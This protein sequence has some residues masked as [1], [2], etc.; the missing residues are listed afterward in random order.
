VFSKL[1]RVHDDT[2]R[3]FLGVTTRRWRFSRQ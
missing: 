2:W 3:E 1:A